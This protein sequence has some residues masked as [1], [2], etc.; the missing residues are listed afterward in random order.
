MLIPAANFGDGGIVE[1]ALVDKGE[2]TGMAFDALR[3]EEV[4]R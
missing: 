2:R 3:P 4:G 1:D